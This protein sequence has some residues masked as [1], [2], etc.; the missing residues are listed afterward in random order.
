MKKIWIA[1]CFLPSLLLAQQ[2]GEYSLEIQNDAGDWLPFRMSFIQ[3]GE[4]K[5]LSIRNATEYI[6]LAPQVNSSDSILYHF[7]DYNAEIVFKNLESDEL[8]GYWINHE[9]PIAKKRPLKAVKTSES[10][11][12]SAV[13]NTLSGKWK[14]K[15]QLPTR[16]YDAIFYLEQKD[17]KLTGTMRTRSGDYRFLEGEVK[18]DEFYLS[19]FQGSMIF[20]L[21]GKLENDQLEGRI[22]STSSSETLF[23]AEKNDDFQLPDSK[24]ITKLLNNESFNL[25]L[26][27]EKGVMQ[28]FEKLT[29]GKVSIVTIFGTW[30]PNCVDEIDYF[31]Q[32]KLKF[33]DLKIIAVAFEYAKQEEEQQR[34]VQGFKKRKKIA[35]QFLIGGQL[36]A[37]NVQEKFP[38]IE[39]TGIYPTSFL[40]DKKGTIREIYTGFNGPATGILYDKF[41]EEFESE[42][43]QLLDE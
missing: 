13:E 17:N 43:Q 4:Q 30:C 26:K 39:H 11:L 27:D 40:V 1:L 16:S 42:I 9:S 32:L 19:S 36:G 6:Q 41:R 29:A 33:P 25:N 7:I 23:F 12:T 34:R 37:E 3:K 14:V 22:Y 35:T 15:V 2:V 31:K 8:Q 24:S 5:H 18:G 21:K 20:Q 10:L 38:M 28:D